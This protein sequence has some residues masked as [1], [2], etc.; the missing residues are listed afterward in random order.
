M[1]RGAMERHPPVETPEPG[2]RR[3]LAPRR[4]TLGWVAPTG[5]GARVSSGVGGPQCRER[6]SISAAPWSDDIMTG[7]S[8]MTGKGDDAGAAGTARDREARGVRR[9]RLRGW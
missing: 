3:R 6:R 1:K 7:P 5:F 4:E 2:P 8:L 9:R